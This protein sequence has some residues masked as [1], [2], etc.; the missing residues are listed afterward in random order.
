ME[1]PAL[2]IEQ[3]SIEEA[4]AE[5]TESKGSVTFYQGLGLVIGL[6]V[7]SGIFSSPNQIHVHS[8]SY[9]ASIVVWCV[10][11]L[12]AWCGASCYAELG[13]AFPNNGGTRQYLAHIF[14]ERVAFLY[15]W[16]ALAV[17][18]PGSAAIISIVLADYL[19]Q[20]PIFKRLIA[21]GAVALIA[22]LNWFG[23]GSAASVYFLFF[24]AAF[25]IGVVGLACAVA[26]RRDHSQDTI[27]GDTHS[28]FDIAIALYGGIWAYDGWDNLNFLVG[29]M[30][31]PKRDLP[32][33]ISSAMP[34]VILAYCIVNCAYFAALSG[35]DLDKSTSVV[36][37]LGRLTGSKAIE[38]AISFG[39]ALSCAG[40]LNAS[41]TSMVSLVQVVAQSGVL[42]KALMQRKW[43]LVSQVL[44][45]GAYCAIGEFKQLV[46]FYGAAGYSFYLLTVVGLLILRFREPDLRRPFKAWLIAPILFILLSGTLLLRTAL[47]HPLL[48]LTVIGF[49]SAG[50]P[51]FSFAKAR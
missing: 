34:L 49:I 28:L 19:S 14:G 29:D 10:S 16:T 15:S 39:V 5:E 27:W 25:L 47:S 50:I 38:L 40:A 46:A 1:D 45:T 20:A 33:V 43:A 2:D 41:I 7:G 37:T 42:P 32:K 9:G 51:L 13:C 22:S 18:K 44:A 12:L 3:L 6:Q 26:A 24:K 23:H 48:M 36:L 21:F 30:R 11:G 31:N 17:L 8:G 35:P 4:S